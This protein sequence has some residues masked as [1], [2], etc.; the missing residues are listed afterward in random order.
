MNA[1]TRTCLSW[2]PLAVA[3][4]GTFAF[5]YIGIQQNFRQTLNDPQIQLADDSATALS[6]GA[7]VDQVIPSTKVDIQTSLSPWIAV[8]NDSHL[9]IASSG[10]LHGVA[11]IIPSG[12][13]DSARGGDASSTSAKQVRE[14]RL[15]WQP[16]SGVRQAIVVTDYN[17]PNGHGYVV[18]GRNMREVEQRESALG[19][20]ALYAWIVTL[21]A[22]FAF[23]FATQ[24][25]RGNS[26]DLRRVK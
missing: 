14:D 6:A 23:Q 22:S 19:L 17:G 25:Y 24:W 9:L 21:L 12:V 11:P 1:L 10:E 4:T 18:A 16:E 7:S 5:A 26:T 8:Y 15:T 3:I 2:L 13:F 20:M